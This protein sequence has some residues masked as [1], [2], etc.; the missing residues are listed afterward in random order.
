MSDFGKVKAVDVHQDNDRKERIVDDTGGRPNPWV[1]E[2]RPLLGMAAGSAIGIC[3]ESGLMLPGY[4]EAT[5]FRGLVVRFGQ[6]GVV[7]RVEAGGE[8]VLLTAGT[9]A[10]SAPAPVAKTSADGTADCQ[11]R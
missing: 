6:G 4:A 1:L 5:R 11:D 8:A 9:K 10:R 3:Q 7:G 2:M